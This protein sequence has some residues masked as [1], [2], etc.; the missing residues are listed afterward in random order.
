MQLLDCT[1]APNPRRV[2]IFMA[3]KGIELP[4]REIDLSAGEQFSE[5]FRRI[6]PE[7]A[8]PVLE[9]DD[10]SAICEVLAICDYL[11]SQFPGQA[12]LGENARQRAEV[13]MWNSRLEF[14]G[15]LAVAEYIR[16]TLKGFK[17][18]AISG[19][20]NYPQIPELAERGR[21]RAIAY[22]QRLDAHLDGREFIAT[23]RYTL[24]DISAQVA[25]DF[26]RWLKLDLTADCANLRRWHEAVSARPSASA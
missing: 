4:R 26:A 13:L 3:E 5:A 7:C 10:G 24:A 16:N 22:F 6:N 15:L 9:L 2:R 19:A 11:E 23:E 14:N 12:L 17:D 8:V 21:L 18:R 1:R 25:V 20:Q